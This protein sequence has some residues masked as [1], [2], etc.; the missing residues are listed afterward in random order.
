MEEILTCIAVDDNRLFINQL[1]ACIDEID[2][3]N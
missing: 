1:E 3:W 2:W